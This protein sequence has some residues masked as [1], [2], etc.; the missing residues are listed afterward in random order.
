MRHY[1]L[2]RG[3]LGKPAWSG[4]RPLGVAGSLSEPTLSLGGPAGL[5]FGP[6]GSL[7]GPAGYLQSKND[8][9][10]LMQKYTKNYNILSQ[11]EAGC[12]LC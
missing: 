1:S 3:C 12:W 11:N 6:A 10:N 9:C 2:S 8:C 5:L 7:S 4:G